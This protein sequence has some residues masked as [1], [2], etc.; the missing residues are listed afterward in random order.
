MANPDHPRDA[1]SIEL[2]AEVHGIPEDV[3]A[4]IATGPG[5][6]L[7]AR[8]GGGLEADTFAFEWVPRRAAG[9]HHRLGAAAAVGPGPP[10]L[11]R[12]PRP[13][14]EGLRSDGRRARPRV[15]ALT[16]ALGLATAA[17]GAELA[18][19][20]ASRRPSPARSTA[21]ARALAPRR[22]SAHRR[23]GRRLCGAVGLRR[24]ALGRSAG[25]PFGEARRPSRRAS[26]RAGRRG[27][28]STS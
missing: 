22:A 13:H 20:A 11:P 19:G 12:L 26:N 6:V 23:A 16:S 15:R 17:E 3:W 28:A 4:A 14:G 10:R 21:C 1:R 18:T 25:L 2:A 27:C 8:D 9:S 7:A 24:G 5:I